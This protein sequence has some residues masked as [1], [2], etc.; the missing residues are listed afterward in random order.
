VRAPRPRPSLSDPDRS[1]PGTGA[2]SPIDEDADLRSCRV[3]SVPDAP[4]Q[5]HEVLTWPEPQ[6]DALLHSLVCRRE[7]EPLA[8]LIAIADTDK[9]A[10]L[11]LLRALRDLDA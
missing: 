2:N 1:K 10:R 4:R 6:R 9:A 5:L 7:L 8:Q 11:R 3:A